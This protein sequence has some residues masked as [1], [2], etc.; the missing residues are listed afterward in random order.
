MYLERHIILLPEKGHP[1]LPEAYG[2]NALQIHLFFTAAA[3]PNTLFPPFF[4][5]ESRLPFHTIVL[6]RGMRTV[7]S[8]IRIV[9]RVSYSVSHPSYDI[10]TARDLVSERT[11]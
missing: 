3:S 2:Q 6:P 8:E 9:F 1:A 5:P 10:S 7:P 11:S 4:E